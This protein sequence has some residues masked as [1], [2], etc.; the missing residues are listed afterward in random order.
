MSRAN[1]IRSWDA[2]LR[3]GLTKAEILTLC[4]GEMPASVQ[5]ALCEEARDLVATMRRNGTHLT[6]EQPDLL[7]ESA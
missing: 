6:D 3:I 5:A 4:R 1:T 7:K 2:H